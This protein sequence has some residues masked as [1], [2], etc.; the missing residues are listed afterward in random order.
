M[1]VTTVSAVVNEASWVSDA[2]REHVRRAVAATGY[3]PNRLARGLK[4]KRGYAVGVIVSDLTNPFF[5]EIVRYLGLALREHERNFFLCDS[6]HRFELGQ[7]NFNLLVEQ[8]VE[9][10]VLIGDSVPKDTVASFV[11]R[12]PLVP[13]IAVERDYGLDRVSSVLVDTERGAYEATAH[14]L[15]GGRRRVA[16]ITGP[17]AGPGSGTYGQAQRRDGYAR[18]VAETG[19]SDP[20]LVVE[21]TFRYPSGVEAM[22]RLL[23]LDRPPDAVL[24]ANDL[25][26]LGAIKAVQDTGRTVP[27]DVALVGFD[28]IP[29]A[30]ITAPALTTV[31]MPKAEIGR[32]VADLLLAQMEDG[33]A[34]VPEHRVLT[35]SLVLRESAPPVPA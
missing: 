5:T 32:V 30:A 28:D 25:M 7:S 3:V 31:A 29:T 11:E 35:P 12:V 24:A 13:V 15:R 4:T 22:E 17:S 6:D 26:A 20:D 23:A 16:M 34:H 1:S 33:V 8:R 14:L 27:G 21:G 10:L 2:T 9:G 19:A 18:A